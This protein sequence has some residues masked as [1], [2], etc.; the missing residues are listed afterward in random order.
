MQKLFVLGFL[1]LIC[2]FCRGHQ[3][4]LEQLSRGGGI[5]IL[6]SLLQNL[7]G[8]MID[9]SVLAAVQN[10]VEMA[11]E[12]KDARIITQIYN[13]LLLDFRIWSKTCF[14]IQIS[15][16]HFLSSMLRDDRKLFKKK[17]GVQFI[18]DTIQLYYTNN[19]GKILNSKIMFH[20]K[21]N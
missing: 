13:S 20:L 19:T 12:S 9:P 6:G 4:N 7:D 8:S 16:I 14:S 17:F 11:R 15:F 3:T 5:Y 18:L 21:Y 2:N 10:L 1:N